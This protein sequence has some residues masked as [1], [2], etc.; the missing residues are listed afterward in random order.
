MIGAGLLFFPHVLYLYHSIHP[1]APKFAK[2]F[3]FLLSFTPI[4]MIGAG[5]INE[6]LV[7]AVHYFLGGLCFGGIGLAAIFGFFFSIVRLK[8]REPWPSLGA[9]AILYGII[10]AGLVYLVSM[11]ITVDVSDPRAMH[12]PEWVMF[13]TLFAWL[14]G[15]YLLI[16]GEKRY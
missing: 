3:A 5:I 1:V 14:V 15:F 8:K 13:V 6:D 2:V 16:P 11:A 12:V 9:V 7:F 4:G 10:I